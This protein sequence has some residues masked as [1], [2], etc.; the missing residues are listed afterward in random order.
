MDIDTIQARLKKVNQ[1]QTLKN[2]G[3]NISTIKEIVESDNIEIIKSQFENRSAQ[4]KDKMNDL[5]KQLCL[6]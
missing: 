3:F 2:R 4:I 5:Q 1:I 6:L